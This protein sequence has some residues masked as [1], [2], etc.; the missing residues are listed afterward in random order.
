MSDSQKTDQPTDPPIDPQLLRSRKTTSIKLPDEV[1]K[2]I[3]EMEEYATDEFHEYLDT[4]IQKIE[5]L[6]STTGK[7]P[8][9][10]SKLLTVMISQQVSSYIQ[11]FF[12]DLP[13]PSRLISKNNAD[14]VILSAEIA[15]AEQAIDTA[16]RSGVFVPDDLE[17][18]EK[19][20]RMII[21]GNRKLQSK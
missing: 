13:L 20:R 18:R 3:S 6:T 10:K 14:N 12:K 11:T 9:F 19:L 15:K 5:G 7:T 8:T 2:L 1:E 16:T 4:Y 21:L 17:E